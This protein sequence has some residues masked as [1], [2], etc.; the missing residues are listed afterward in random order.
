MIIVI[1][2][3]N[4]LGDA[5]MATPAFAIL[6][7]HFENAKFIIIGSKLSVPLFER[8]ERVIKTIIDS[9]KSAKCRVLE[10]FRVAKSLNA[11]IAITF[12]NSFLSALFFYMSGIKTRVGFK[13][14]FRSFLLTDSFVIPKELHQV[15]RY[16]FLINSYLKTN[17]KSGDLEL[18][19]NPKKFDKKMLGINAGATYGSAK[20]WDSYKFAEVAIELSKEY[21]ILLFGSKN[22]ENIVH[23]IEEILVRNSILNYQNLAGKTTILELIDYISSLDLLIT[24]DSGPMHIAGAFKIKT[25]AL[26]GPTD[27]RE[28]NQW[29]NPNSINLSLNLECS[30]CKKRTCPLKHQKCLKEIS[31]DMVLDAIKRF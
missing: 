13:K 19:A 10:L 3:P 21:D 27:Y 22:E 25:I 18:I 5:V 1:R 29:N 11:S 15:E 26:F 23:E 24:N 2:M 30:P 20:R 14:E 8:D 6:K 7:N 16:T 12:T 17:Y 28:T 31:S 9:S 4:W